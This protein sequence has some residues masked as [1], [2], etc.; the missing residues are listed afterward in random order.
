[1]RYLL[2]T[3][4]FIAAMKGDSNVRIALERTP[5]ADLVLSTVVL[6]ELQ[7]GVEKSAYRE[8]NQLKLN[9]LLDQIETAPVDARV[10]RIYAE[11]RADLERQG[12]TI[13]SNDYWIAAHA[14][15][16]GA[17]LVT[18]NVAEFNRVKGLATENWLR[19]MR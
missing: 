7:L 17:T 4:I 11:V 5:L 19:P 3:N 15:A 8:K 18:D 6:G 10:S 13:G 14:L 1:M 9:A 12:T 2:D 16:L